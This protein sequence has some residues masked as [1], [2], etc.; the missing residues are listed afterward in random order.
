MLKL[1][2]ARANDKFQKVTVLG[3]PAAIRD[4]YWQ[5]TRNYSSSD[6]TAIGVIVVSNLDGEICTDRI[7][8]G[9]YESST[10]MCSV[11]V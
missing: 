3:E 11:E 5:L 7:L 4:L 8:H 6:G 10:N 1:T 9:P 2:Y